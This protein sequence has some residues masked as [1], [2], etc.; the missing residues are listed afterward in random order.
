MNGEDLSE[1]KSDLK[2]EKQQLHNIVTKMNIQYEMLQKQIN[3]LYDENT[4]L[5]QELVQKN[6]EL[7]ILEARDYQ[8]MLHQNQVFSRKFKRL[9]DYAER[10]EKPLVSVIISVYNTEKYLVQCLESVKNQTLENIEIICIDDGSSDSSRSIIEQYCKSDSRFMLIANNKNQGAGIS[11]NKGLK[12]AH[13]KYIICLDSDDFFEPQFLEKM[14]GYAENKAADAVICRSDLYYTDTGRYEDNNSSINDRVLPEKDVF[15]FLDMPFYIL[16][17]CVGW[18]W[19]KLVRRS[20]ITDYDISFQENVR[21]N[22]D[23]VYTCGVMISA[24]AIAIL[25]YKG[26]HH[27]KSTNTSLEDTYSEAP[28][29]FYRAGMELLKRLKYQGKAEFL[30]KSYVNRCL[31]KSIYYLNQLKNMD[32]EKY[33]YIKNMLK[34]QY[35]SDMKI[36]KHKNEKDYFYQKKAYEVFLDI[37][38]EE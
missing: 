16:D 13:G 15:T 8:Y 14:T 20:L 27:R 12:A 19:D 7:K 10:G 35:F 6:D 9:E 21:R 1:I 23:V 32:T 24:S 28:D 18:A 36:L 33:D 4:R 31:G 5:R 3:Q 37:M 26:V 30:E 22:E 25:D 11:R 38:N 2:Y 29:S 34:I 17:F